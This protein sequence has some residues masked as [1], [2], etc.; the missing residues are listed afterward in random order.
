VNATCFYRAQPQ[1]RT[2]PLQ[3]NNKDAREEEG[4]TLKLQGP[5]TDKLRA[6]QLIGIE[7]I[8]VS[9]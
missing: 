2:Q 1:A 5:R 6:A 7:I 3:T 4:P 8:T 9:I